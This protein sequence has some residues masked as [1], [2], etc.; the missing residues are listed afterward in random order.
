MPGT[1]YAKTRFAL[2]PGHDGIDTREDCN[3]KIR[4]HGK[5]ARHQAREGLELET[6]L[7]KNRRL[8]GSADCRR[9]PRPD[10]TDKTAGRE[11][12]RIVRAVEVGN[13]YA[14]RGADARHRDADAADPSPALSLLPH[15]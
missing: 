10:E 7:R 12:R 15:G 13:C 6:R 3:D 14:Q 1:S 4:S 9:H 8:F 5:A 11:C 2:W